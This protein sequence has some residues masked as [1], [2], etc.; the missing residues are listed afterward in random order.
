M[1]K[2][3]FHTHSTYCDGKN[4]PRELIE[5]ALELG[6]TSLGFS[7]HA[8]CPIPEDDFSMPEDNTD[9]Y[10]AEITALKREYADRIKIFCGTELDLYSKVDPTG[11]DFTIASVHYI[12]KDGKYLSVD[13]NAETEKNNVDSFY[14]GDFDAYCED[15]Y[16]LVVEAAKLFKPTFMGHLDLT[17]KYADINGRVESPRY[18]EAARAAIAEICRM[19]I[20]FEINTGAIARKLRTTPYPSETLLRM[21]RDEGGK[22][23]INSDCHQKE[24]LNCGF[25]QAEALAQKCGFDGHYIVT[26]GGLE[27]VSF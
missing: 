10:V 26:D 24:Y 1:I 22:I 7:G 21:I 11:Y 20:P 25:E 15:Y 12:K 19:D 13:Y 17:M 16:K 18:L 3:N 9:K 2:S 5:R 27:F 4:T 14:G 8:F 23:I 6:F